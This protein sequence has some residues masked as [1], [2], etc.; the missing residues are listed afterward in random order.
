M[1]RASYDLEQ[2]NFDSF[3]YILKVYEHLTFSMLLSKGNISF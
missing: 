2:E 3:K 1:D